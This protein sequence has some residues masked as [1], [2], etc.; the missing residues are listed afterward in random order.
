MMR[1]WQSLWSV[2]GREEEVLLLLHYYLL[3]NLQNW[4]LTRLHE[5]SC[6]ALLIVTVV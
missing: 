6:T 4:V 5:S 1:M 2:E 3:I